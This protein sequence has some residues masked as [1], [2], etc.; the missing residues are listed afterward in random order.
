MVA[1]KTRRKILAVFMD[2][3]AENT[4]TDIDL[5]A[6]SDRCGIKLSTLRG[7]YRDRLALIEDFTAMIDQAVLDAADDVDP[8]ETPKDRLFD[9]LMA[10]LDALAPFKAGVSQ[11][12]RD[13]SKDPALAMALNS[14]MLNSMR[15]MLSAADI[16]A[17]GLKGGIKL[18]GLV[19]AYGRVVRVWLGDEDAG[20]AKTMAALD[21]ELRRGEGALRRLDRVERFVSR[22]GSVLER[23]QKRRRSSEDTPSADAAA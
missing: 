9:L 22:I 18:Q 2:M 19:V 4:S 8:E 3:V 20:L 13:A 21:R 6:L 15:W 12:A 5:R 16:E 23:A 17:S 10:R 11:I 1:E 7:T 14:R